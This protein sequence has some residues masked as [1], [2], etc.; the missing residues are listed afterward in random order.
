VSSGETLSFLNGGWVEEGG[1]DCTK[2]TDHRVATTG[3][4]ERA[5]RRKLWFV[6]G[7]VAFAAETPTQ[8]AG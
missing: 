6:R 7:A 1:M 3:D 8:L 5:L 2:I 4:D